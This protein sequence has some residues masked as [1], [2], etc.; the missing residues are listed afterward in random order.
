MISSGFRQSNKAYFQTFGFLR[1]PGL[2]AEDIGRLIEG[3]EE[4]FRSNEPTHVLTAQQDLLQRTEGSR[5]DSR[6]EII[7]PNF[8]DMSD[9]LRSLRND[10]R[11][12][13]IAESMIGTAYEYH[14][15]DGNL[16]YSDT[17]WHHDCY[18]S[19]LERYHIKLSFYL[20]NLSR[21]SGAIRLIPGTNHYESSYART[22]RETLYRAPRDVRKLYGVSADEIPSWSL[23]TEPGDVLVWN[24]RTLHASF[25][26][27]ERR[28]S[29][30]ICFRALT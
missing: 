30:S 18:E 5:A 23:E 27:G 25:N 26:G 20:E 28:R 24:F 7:A 3:F 16:F 13:G 10:R 4:V 15:S 6:R 12:L 14:G 9:K 11:I 22:L 8:V 21:E 2:F 29:F 17:S 1:V 19:P